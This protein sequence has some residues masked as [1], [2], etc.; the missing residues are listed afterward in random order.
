MSGQLIPG[1]GAPGGPP[2]AGNERLTFADLADITLLKFY[3]LAWSETSTGR[4]AARDL[5]RL[6]PGPV[7]DSL[8]IKAVNDLAG[9]ELLTAMKAQ[10]H[11][12]Y[13][14]STKGITHIE[15]LL[16]D[17]TSAPRRYETIGVAL[18]RT[19]GRGTAAAAVAP[20][21]WKRPD[22]KGD[23]SPEAV[24]AVREGLQALVD[25]AGDLSLQEGERNQVA[26]RLQA[27][28]ALAMAPT[29]AWG[30]TVELLEPLTVVKPVADK[31]SAIIGRIG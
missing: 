3:D 15:T 28:L 17:A 30:K 11:I 8:F 26:A 2:A 6:K 25:Q 10:D 31:V 4:I 27:A 29:P 21:A 24:D 13:A 12:I 23:L 14:I 9:R 19:T 7:S 22:Y 1:P 18:F 5:N 20:D 16:E